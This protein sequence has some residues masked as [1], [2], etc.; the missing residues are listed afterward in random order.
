MARNF[1]LRSCKTQRSET[2]RGTKPLRLPDFIVV[3]PPR[4]GTTWLDRVLRGHVGLPAEVKETQ[5]FVWNF[6]LGIQWYGK[7]F[8]HCDPAKLVGEIAP[9]YFD[10][11]YA[12]ERIAAVIPSCKIV[13]SLRDPVERLYSQYKTWHRSGL[14]RGPF[15]YDLLR[16][17]LGADGGY[18]F[19]VKAWQEVCGVENVLVQLYE[20]L[21]SSGQSYIDV[22]CSFI[23]VPR[24]DLA[25]TES[26]GRKV[27]P[28]EQSPRSL[29]LA[30]FGEG[31]RTWAT[32]HPRLGLA[33]HLEAETPLWR[34]F[35]AGGPDYPPLDSEIE[36]NLRH[37]LIPEFEELEQL[38][39][40]D[41][42]V[43]KAPRPHGS[44]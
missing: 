20:D 8:R 18:A 10:K 42:T 33:R 4:T 27:N 43:W 30:R 1:H 11:H 12:R 13:C 28:S 25:K 22:L 26:G 34:L 16:R 35:F 5:F 41:L 39:D 2:G 37:R 17:K 6:E 19:N 24:I 9:T 14:V 3:G 29:A 7:F 32:R 31:L 36:K 15:D 44:A 38:L 23:G 40:R 21:K